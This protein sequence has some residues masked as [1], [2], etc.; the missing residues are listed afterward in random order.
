ML[1]LALQSVVGLAFKPAMAASPELAS[2]CP[3]PQ[4]W[5]FQTERLELD[6]LAQALAS[7]WAVWLYYLL[8][9]EPFKVLET[10]QTNAP[11]PDMR[12]KAFKERA[13]QKTS[14]RNPEILGVK[15]PS[16][17]RRSHA[18]L[19]LGG[20]ASNDISMVLGVL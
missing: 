17:C 2:P 3:N 6:K 9:L 1:L 20:E 15:L 18:T 13:V 7:D 4:T 16:P 19:D 14:G 5:G 11:V 10:I 12:L 8:T